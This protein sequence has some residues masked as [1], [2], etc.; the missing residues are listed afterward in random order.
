MAA[1]LARHW[2]VFTSAWA[3]DAEAARNRRR[4]LETEFLPAALEVVETPAS[5]LA[6]GGLWF[7]II[8]VV[9]AL[10][11]SFVGKLDVVITA[12]GKIIPSERV[13]VVQP[14]E[15]GV[16]RAI[17]VEDGQEVRAGQV[18]I[19]L[20]PTTT[21]AEDTQARTGLAAA[22]LDRARSRAM[23]SYLSG[24][25]IR[26]MPPAGTPAE[27][28][29]V[30]L[31]LIRS[32]IEE[33]EARRGVLNRQRSEHGAELAAA[34]AEEAKLQETLPL[35]DRQ[36]NGRR[37]LAE[38]GY[39]PKL[40]VLE[41]EEQ[42]VERLR[43]IDVQAAQAQ[44]AHAAI[45]GIDEQ[46]G[47]LRAEL[48]RSSVKDYSDAA[49]NERLRRSEIDKTN[50]RNRLMR[51]TSPVDGVV[52]QLSIHTLGGVVQPAQALLVVVPRTPKLLVEAKVLN[53]DVGFVRVGQPVRV[54][55]D[56]FP[57]TDYGTVNAR[58]VGISPD[59]VED[60]K[61]GLYYVARVRLD[62][63]VLRYAGRA[64]RLTPGM[65]VS[66]EI[67]TARRRIIQYLL[68]PLVTRF[69]EAGR[70]R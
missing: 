32:Q 36:L 50:M 65:S 33:Y 54:K 70:E 16:V 55:V 58:L 67:K 40:K 28:A 49:D 5:P 31:N 4:K 57:F 43:N 1:G 35:L 48:M 7:L 6:R 60:E 34:Q 37:T 17:H 22:E 69:D 63:D 66:A 45:A 59:A 29:A 9:L 68:S 18:L 2:Q 46:L 44:K 12:P 20:D 38:K 52:Q 41:L 39:Y 25:G 15:L 61:L 47:Q 13:K 30:Q 8:A 27:M 62:E 53:K 3:M 56:A 21:S 23:M 14:T 19:E 42:R 51:I 11:W 64:A 10:L 24:G 26:F